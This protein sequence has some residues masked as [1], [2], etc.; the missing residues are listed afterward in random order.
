[1]KYAHDFIQFSFVVIRYILHNKFTSC[2]CPYLSGFHWHRDN[3]VITPKKDVTPHETELT[4]RAHTCTE[5]VPKTRF[6]DVH[7][8][9][10]E[11]VHKT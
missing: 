2:I 1:M 5:N 4:Q 10:A 6:Q 3:R 8:V 9:N 11:N 7:N